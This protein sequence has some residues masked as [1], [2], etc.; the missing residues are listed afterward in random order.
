MV[1]LFLD[2]WKEGKPKVRERE[3][4]RER[5]GCEEKINLHSTTASGQSQLES[6]STLKE[7]QHQWLETQHH[8]LKT[9]LTAKKKK[10]K[11]NKKRIRALI[12]ETAR[13]EKEEEGTHH[14]IWRR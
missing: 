2:P 13:A 4:E 8:K 10:K 6:Q 11:R 5:E 9:P 14:W 12:F 7:R 1:C 3:K